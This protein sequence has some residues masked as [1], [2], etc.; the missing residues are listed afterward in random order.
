[1]SNDNVIR[2]HNAVEESAN[3]HR[4]VPLCDDLLDRRVIFF[5][6]EVDA[7]SSN[8]LL[9]Q[10]MYLE[11]KDNT[12][13]ITICFNS[14]GGLVRSGLAVYDYMKLMKSPLRTVC[15]GTAA[16]MAALLF[17]AGD[18]REMLEH[19]KLMIHDP[20]ISG[21]IQSKKPHELAK[22]AEDLQ[23]D[24]EITDKII[25]DATGKTVEEISEITKNDTYF[26]AQEALDFGLATS[27]VTEL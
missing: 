27:L 25:A 16:S 14:P 9:L 4:L 3:G 13:E 12:Q 19:T 7:A 23:K 18:K 2:Y 24:K 17:L 6:N 22:L 5:T 21:T 26:T 11:K 15:V 1:M 10:L 8:E 20:S